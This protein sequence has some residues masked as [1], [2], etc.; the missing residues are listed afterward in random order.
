MYTSEP[1]IS[2]ILIIYCHISN[3]QY[4]QLLTHFSLKSEKLTV[5]FVNSLIPKLSRIVQEAFP[6]ANLLRLFLNSF[7][8]ANI[9]WHHLSSIWYTKWEKAICVIRKYRRE[10]TMI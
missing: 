10:A 3:E 7:K 2:D 1:I 4:F 5:N 9:Q 8:K 6:R